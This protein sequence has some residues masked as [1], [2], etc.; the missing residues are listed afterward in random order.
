MY[1]FLFLN[2]STSSGLF[3]VWFLGQN[4]EKRV[5]KSHLL[6][7]PHHA[8]AECYPE[9]LREELITRSWS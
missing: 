3:I 7:F 6:F 4:K 1:I 5:Y 8:P 2:F 9:S